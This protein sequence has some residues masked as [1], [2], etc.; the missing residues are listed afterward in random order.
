MSNSQK[1]CP[2]VLHSKKRPVVNKTFSLLFFSL[3]STTVLFI[4]QENTQSLVDG[5]FAQD[6]HMRLASIR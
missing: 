5:L 6:Q 2:V 4:P 1:L 3:W